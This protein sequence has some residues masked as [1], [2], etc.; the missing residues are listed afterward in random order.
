MAER[1]TVML[2]SQTVFCAVGAAHLAGEG[3]ILN[4]LREKGFVLTPVKFEFLSE[5]CR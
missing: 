1:L 4:Y 3:G 2:E 5:G